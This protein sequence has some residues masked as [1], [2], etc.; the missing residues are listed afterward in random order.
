V[1]LFFE[2]GVTILDRFQLCKVITVDF[3]LENLLC[4]GKGD[5]KLICRR[6]DDS[7]GQGYNTIL[8]FNTIDGN[9]LELAEP[10]SEDGGLF[11]GGGQENELD[12][13]WNEDH[14]LFPDFAAI[15]VIDIVAFIKDD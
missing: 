9:F 6:I 13:G 15:W 3:V 5:F 10:L 14:C 11:Q 7:V 4:W 2:D 1:H 12:C 8:S